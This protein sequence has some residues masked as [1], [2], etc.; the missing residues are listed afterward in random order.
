MFK[1]VRSI[2]KS[3]S[4][5][6]DDSHCETMKGRRQNIWS[7]EKSSQNK[8]KKNRKTRNFTVYHRAAAIEA[9]FHALF[10]W[11]VMLSVRASEISFGSVGL[12]W[13]VWCGT[14]LSLLTAHLSHFVSDSIHLH[15]PISSHV[16][17]GWCASM[18]IFVLKPRKYTNICS[19]PN[20]KAVCY[21][22]AKNG[23]LSL[24]ILTI[25]SG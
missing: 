20:R 2:C 25:Y 21:Y 19:L 10:G 4:S 14:A 9:A 11:C 1:K 23:T 16:A 24:L 5:N 22:T 17:G 13:G 15:G 12:W 3:G 6:L 7:I 18:F 8:K